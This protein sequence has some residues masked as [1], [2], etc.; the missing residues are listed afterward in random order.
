[1]I[2]PYLTHEMLTRIAKL[3]VAKR[4]AAMA[5]VGR[6]EWQRC[7]SD[8]FYWLDSRR[9]LVPYVY[10]KDPKTV[11]TCNLC[12]DGATHYFNKLRVHLME[13]HKTEVSD[14]LELQRL[15]TALDT[16]RPLDLEPNFW[17]MKPI[18]DQ[19]LVEPLMVV[20][21]SRDMM[22]TWL[23]V[24]CYTW[25]TLFHRGKQNIFQS[26][27]AT[28]SRELVQRAH[29][30]WRN[31]PKWL[32]DVHPAKYQEGASKAGYLVVSSLEDS[33]IIG[34]PQGADKI[35]QF[36]P[37]GMFSDEAAFNPDAGNCF[38][39]LKPAIQAGGRYTAIS[40]A[41]PSFFM[42][43]CRDLTNIE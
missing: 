28:K 42:A 27:N 16:I 20:E 25:D 11:Y 40:S 43:I 34:F 13:S 8:I 7:A 15:F 24:M 19:W 18:I 26:E 5:L 33:E 4:P 10:T 22:A 17:Y 37:S 21:K 35:R 30:L 39:A 38:A 1:M 6:E 12:A 41:N 23:V 9:H 29:T 31:Q 3:P 36:H 2:S 14:E 32:R